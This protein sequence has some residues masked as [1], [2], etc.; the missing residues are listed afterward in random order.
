MAHDI[1]ITVYKARETEKPK[2]GQYRKPDREKM[3]ETYRKWKLRKAQG[4]FDLKRFL[5]DGG[6]LPGH[7]NDKKKS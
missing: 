3:E 2:A 4:A 5:G 6:T 1:P 7:D